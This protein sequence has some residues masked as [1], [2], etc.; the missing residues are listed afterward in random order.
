M[1]LNKIKLAGFKSFVDPTTISFPNNLTAIVGPNG[2]GKSNIIDA[3]T[4]VMGESSAKNLRGEALTD[5]IFNGTTTRKPVGQ[6]SVELI[7]NNTEGKLSG[8]FSSCAE[9]SLRRLITRDS[10]AQ[11]FLNNVRCRKRDIVDLFL[12][13]GLGPR[14]YS[15]IGQNMISRII[16]AKPEEMRAYLEEAAGVSKY[17]ER[18]KET[19]NRLKHT[20]ENLNRL[21]DIRNELQKQLTILERQAQAAEKFRL[22][23][24]EERQLRAKWLA[25]QYKELDNE[26]IKQSLTI[27]QQETK[28][29]AIQTNL[30]T[31]QQQLDEKREKERL[32][33]ENFQE[34][35]QNY[36][37]TGN[38]V[39]K[40]E[41]EIQ[42]NKERQVEW[43]NNIAV[44]KAQLQQNE[45]LLQKT[46]DELKA[47][48]NSC[49]AFVPRIEE[50]KNKVAEIS[51]L[52]NT[53]EDL[54]QDWETKWENF[55][56][57][58]S[59]LKQDIE[60]KHTDMIHVQHEITTI[61]E[62]LTKLTTNDVTST[63]KLTEEIGKLNA[64]LLTERNMLHQ[65]NIT[66]NELRNQY[67]CFH[68]EDEIINKKLHV[69]RSELHALHG[70]NASLQALQQ[71][72]LGQHET[73]VM[74]W[75]KDNHLTENSRLAE[76]LEVEAGWEFAVEK[77]LNVNLQAIYIKDQTQIRSALNKLKKGN[78][79]FYS[80]KETTSINAA[81]AIKKTLLLSK[82]K[83]KVSLD[84]LL[85]DIYIAESDAEAF[86]MQ[87]NLVAH[88]SVI[89]K[90]GLWLGP[91]W[92]RL[93][94]T[95]HET[96]GVF[97]R[98][99]ELKNIALKITKHLA[100][101]KNLEAALKEN[102][103]QKLAAEKKVHQAQ[104]SLHQVQTNILHKEAEIKTLEQRLFDL[105]N[106][107]KQELA[108]ESV[109]KN[110]LTKLKNV[111]QEG[112]QFL[113]TQQEILLIEQEKRQTLLHEKENYRITISSL[114]EQLDDKKEQLHALHLEWEGI[115][116]QQNA[117]TLNI[118]HLKEQLLALN[119]RDK[120]LRLN[121]NKFT[122]IKEL[123]EKLHKALEKRL[124]VEIEIKNARAALDDIHDELKN[125]ELKRQGV[126]NEVNACR[127]LLEQIRLVSQTIKTKIETVTEKLTELAVDLTSILPLLTKEDSE[128]H[129]EL[130]VQQIVQR[131]SR[132]GAINLAA[133]EELATCTERKTYLDT[134]YQDLIDGL[135]TL[136][137]AI[138]KIDK[139][140]RVRFKETFTEVN[141]HFGK[142]FPKIFGGG[143]AYLE[144][145]E[146]NLLQSDVLVM[147][148]P[149]GKRNS[150]IQLLSGGEKA[151]TAIALIFSIFQLNPAPFCL[152]DEVDAPLDDANISRFCDLVKMMSQKTQFIFI[153]HNKLAIEMAECLMGVTMQE[154]G[155][156]RLVSVNVAEAVKMVEV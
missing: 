25:V 97:K 95:S 141:N 127:N 156:S 44:T 66:V 37:L 51:K 145:T 43:Q 9:I 15:I 143:R 121:E 38:E 134:Q 109:L 98:E 77:I 132:L 144:L 125:L 96:Q 68:N 58:S 42:Y 118:N 117:L 86:A 19:E 155:V 94:C 139:E 14:S 72:A 142:L 8:E 78:V 93:F 122:F 7:F 92:L 104:L 73:Y 52:L 88:E 27:K 54:F 91:D 106:K 33:N 114:R 10:D 2:C 61:T 135:K 49:E 16:E 148:C 67:A 74:E 13:T 4:W 30:F 69:I 26:L 124:S 129:L 70:Q 111:L 119:A 147:A 75:L 128:E 85:Q 108:E 130:Q 63:E 133:I 39:S 35:Q 60:V 90:N 80:A 62:R 137:E 3:I 87:K 102:N 57:L 107:Q 76:L 83:S 17:K 21:E 103:D 115:K 149:P 40:L 34:T 1:H 81:T 100:L 32:A 116:L 71:M 89:T 84:S 46:E 29:V 45:L 82:I 126:E 36:Y 105:V 64:A 123:E 153:S 131:I 5:V 110:Q 41:Q 55:N 59:K 101:E 24:E 22:L 140:T 79:F 31:L 146:N 48:T 11:Y 20:K 28:L 152:L 154:P 65:H 151:M 99:Q 23:K 12:G 50:S 113:N 150:T 18:R 53:E 56:E 112:Q 136:E 6:A 47:V 120:E 138:E